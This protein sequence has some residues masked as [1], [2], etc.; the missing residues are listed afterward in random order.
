MIPVLHGDVVFDA[1]QGFCIFSAE[2]VLSVLARKFF[3]RYDRVRVIFCGDTDGVYD[4]NG[5]TVPVITPRLFK[6]IREAIGP[7][8]TADVTGG[9]LH[10]IEAS[11]AL[12]SS[13]GIST[14]IVNGNT[15]GALKRAIE[16][17]P[18]A[19]TT[20]VIKGR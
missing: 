8:A 20:V 13:L 9:M 11:I 1:K 4:A 18:V 17:K 19:R 2:K 14:T 12:A 6:N 3:R 15:P 7:A 5:T 10:K 16:G